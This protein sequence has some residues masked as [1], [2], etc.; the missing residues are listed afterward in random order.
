VD[1]QK[2]QIVLV[3]VLAVVA[4]GAGGYAFLTRERVDPNLGRKATAEPQQR[5]AREVSESDKPD[6]RKRDPKR[7][8]ASRDSEMVGQDR[9]RREVTAKKAP[10]RRSGR[11][12]A[13]KKV[14]KKEV[15]PAA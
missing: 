7:R 11:R 8:T 13:T 4:L 9:K 10:S 3:A 12:G 2:K 6:R 1:K 15:K 14:K 5:R